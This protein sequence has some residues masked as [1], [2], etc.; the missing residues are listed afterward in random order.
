MKAVVNGLCYPLKPDRLEGADESRE[1]RED[2]T[3]ST[4][5]GKRVCVCVCVDPG[6]GAE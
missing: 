4:G 2:T 5:S 6:K 1:G 3:L